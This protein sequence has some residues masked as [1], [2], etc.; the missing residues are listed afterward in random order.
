VNGASVTSPVGFG[1]F[2]DLLHGVDEVVHGLFGFVGLDKES[3][4]H[5]QQELGGGMLAPTI[6]YP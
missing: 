3:I 6:F 5:Q 1:F 2:Q 4:G